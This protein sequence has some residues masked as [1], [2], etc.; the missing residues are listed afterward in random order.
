M[1]NRF[2]T[3]C[4]LI[5]GVSASLAAPA[6]SHE[7]TRADGTA[8]D[9]GWIQEKHTWCCGKYDCRPVAPAQIVFTPRGWTVRGLKGVIGIE[10]V[11]DSE[12]RGPWAC[13]NRVEGLPDH[14]RCLF[15]PGIR[16]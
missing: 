1:S 14:I 4:A 8:V 7:Y 2:R 5:V 6:L 16:G 11:R 15:L 13:D 9:A 10:E 12:G 3:A